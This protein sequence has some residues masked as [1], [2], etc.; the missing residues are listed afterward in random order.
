MSYT[1]YW[2]VRTL[3]QLLSCHFYSNSLVWHLNRH[4]HAI[5]AHSHSSDTDT[6][7]FIQSLFIITLLESHSCKLCSQSLWDTVNFT[8]SF[9]TVTHLTLSPSLSC[10]PCSQS[11]WHTVIF[12][13]SFRIVTRL[14]LW[15]SLFYS[16]SLIWHFDSH[17]HTIL[18]HSHSSWHSHSHF[19]AIFT[20]SF[21]HLMQTRNQS[22]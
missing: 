17:L 14:T 5:F 9:L 15:Q 8:R 13:Q 20:H 1:V 21:S 4:F 16:Q 7:T 11:L 6:V 18:R 2:L 19:H 22:Y 10:N 3:T 12:M